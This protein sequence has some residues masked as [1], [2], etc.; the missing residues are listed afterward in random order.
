MENKGLNNKEGIFTLII[1]K[2]EFDKY[3]INP[4]LNDINKG[5]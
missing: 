4:K 5:N 1:E 3:L 2:K